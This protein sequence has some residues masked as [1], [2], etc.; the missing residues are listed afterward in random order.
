MAETNPDLAQNFEK[1]QLMR[2]LG[3][4]L[5][6][7]DGFEN[8][9][10]K[11][12]LRGVPHTLAMLN[13]RVRQPGSPNPPAERLGWD[14]GGAP[15][16]GTIRD[17]ALGAITQHFT[18]TLSRTPGVD[19]RVPTDEELDALAA[20][21]LALG[22]QA[23]PNLAAMQFTSPVVNRGKQIYLTND[24]VGGT[25]AAGK[26]NNCHGNGGANGPEGDNRNFDIGTE[27]LKDH[28]ADLIAPGV[29][30]R[31]GGFGKTPFVNGA[32]GNGKFNI[33]V[34]IEAADTGPFFHNNS[35]DTIEEAVGYYN[36]NAFN[37][38]PLGAQF[39]L[40]DTG[41]IGIHLETTQVE[42][43]AALLRVLNALENI[44]SSSELDQAAVD[45]KD[46]D[47]ASMLLD[48]A[49]F[50]TRDAVRVL[51][52]RGLHIDAVG[53]LRSAYEK[54]REAAAENSRPRRDELIAEILG[55]KAEAR[56]AMVVTP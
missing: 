25:V 21:Q 20:F 39:K 12:V 56:A 23:D 27:N 46:K 4:V 45:L 32:F 53:K 43:V 6:N 40:Q 2:A 44:R 38:S 33:P 14:G 36:S 16:S 37:T 8:L 18:K 28:P 15:G 54:E 26:C 48:L 29:R 52:E 11:F 7:T 1:P 17:F 13:S 47:K 49:S 42:S 9:Q 50:D 19:F 10:T 3:L 55:L 35:V 51:E 5:E 31:D 22:R 30:P 41:G 24:S 34:V